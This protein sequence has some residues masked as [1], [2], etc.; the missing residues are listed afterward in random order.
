MKNKS[1]QIELELPESD[2]VVESQI[3]HD[4]EAE[5]MIPI[6]KIW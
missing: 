4:D 3:Q 2:Q 1:D 5:I 6:S